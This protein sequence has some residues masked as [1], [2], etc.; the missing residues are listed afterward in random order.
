MTLL[1]FTHCI[2]GKKMASQDQSTQNGY[3]QGPSA[4]ID[5]SYYRIH[6][7]TQTNRSSVGNRSLNREERGYRSPFHRCQDEYEHFASPDNILASLQNFT[8]QFPSKG[9]KYS[10]ISNSAN[11]VRNASFTTRAQMG[12][13][14][15]GVGVSLITPTS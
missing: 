2:P 9:H 14:I 13:I 12:G 5:A 10:N 7:K 1:V 6:S 15:D 11:S 8:V 3:G 4:D